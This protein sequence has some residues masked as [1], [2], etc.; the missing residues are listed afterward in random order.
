MAVKE[1]LP[2]TDFSKMN[3]D[4][5]RNVAEGE[6]VKDGLPATDFSRMNR[7]YIKAVVEESGGGGGGSSDFSTAEVTITNLTNDGAVEFPCIG[8]DYGDGMEAWDTMEI[9]VAEPDPDG[10]TYSIPVF[11]DGT[12]LVISGNP[13]YTIAVTGDITEDSGTV[14]V[15]G[16]G[17]ISVS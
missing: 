13:P 7:E 4:Y 5:I 15:N 16:N 17:T 11:K 9:V 12:I 3:R 6:T 10:M 14:T 2:A 1:G 8:A